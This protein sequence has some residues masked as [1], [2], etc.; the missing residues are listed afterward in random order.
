MVLRLKS[1]H[2]FSWLS[3]MP[4]IEKLEEEFLILDAPVAWVY[5]INFYPLLKSTKL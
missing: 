3:E 1:H 5:V 2:R 4:K